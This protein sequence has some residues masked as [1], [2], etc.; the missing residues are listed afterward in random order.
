[1]SGS[2]RWWKLVLVG[3]VAAGAVTAALWV[4]QALAPRPPAKAREEPREPL[5]QVLAP[6]PVAV[7]PGVYLLGKM[8]PAVAYVVDTSDGLVLIDSGLEARAADVTAQLT[9][10]HLDVHRLRAILLTHVHAD[11]SLGAEHLRALTGARVHAGKGDC[12]ALREG[13]PREA[14]FST[15]YMPDRS[16]HP[17]AVDVELT[18]DERLEFGD[19]QVTVIATPGHTPGSVCYLVERPGL[20][21]LFTG[22]VVSRLSWG[23]RGSLGTYAAYNP[24]LYRGDAKAYLESLRR[25]RALPAPDL[26]LPGHPASDPYPQKPRLGRERWD[27]LLDEGIAELQT[28]VA[29]YE[30]DGANFLDGSPKELLPGLH[31]LG[32]C[33]GTPVYCLDTPKGLYLFDAPGGDALPELLTRRFTERGWAGRQPRSVVLTSADKE[34]TAGLAALVRA[35]CCSVV[36]PPDALKSVQ[37]LCPDGTRVVSAEDFAKSGELDVRVLALGGRGVAPV[38]YEM[39]WAGKMVLASG[40][41]PMNLGLPEAERLHSDVR[42]TAG[43]PEEYVKALRRLAEVKPDIWLTAVPIHGQN[44]NLYGE[45]WEKVL[46]QN[47]QLFE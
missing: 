30:A 31:Y 32:N 46:A 47:R 25:L 8:G 16:P 24:P 20:R 7:A 42:D 27:K 41:M 26:V 10:L 2:G 3:A 13:G 12:A 39:R 36:A 14:F 34:A 4:R 33:G 40:R 15:F 17:T 44:A 21:A 45:D 35:T 11:H 18:G 23:G 1:M 43:G 28:L 38:A 37:R 5:A 9:A 6:A 22:D 19:T 29:R